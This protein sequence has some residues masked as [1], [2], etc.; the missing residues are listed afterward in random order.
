[1]SGSENAKSTTEDTSSLMHLDRQLID[2]LNRRVELVR[3]IGPLIAP[4]V[5]QWHTLLEK[6]AGNEPLIIDWLKHAASLSDRLANP[7]QSIAYLGPMYSFSYLAAA[8]YFGMGAHLVPVNTISAAFEEVQRK[9]ASFAVVPV[10]NNTDGRVVDSLG[11]F[12]KSPVQICGEILLPIHHC[13]LGR[14]DRNE[15]REV[16]SKPQA[17]SQC[18]H[19][20]ATHLPNVKLVEVASTAEAAT[21]AANS[22]SVAAIAS[23]EAGIHYGCKVIAENIEDNTQNIT[24]FAVIGDRHC[25]PT[26]N[27]KTS[28]MFQ[29]SHQ[30]GALA[31]AMIVFKQAGVN[32]TWIESFPLPNRPNEYLFFIELDG[33]RE[34][35]QVKL[36]IA[37]LRSHAVR[38]DVLG[39][40]PKGQVG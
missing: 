29:L 23:R 24:R 11:M 12:A 20:L 16:H 17:L 10:E 37:Q 5:T 32:L 25:P 14:A 2:L 30:P 34:S 8:R 31:D 27:D 19:W 4:S 1:M 21:T 36:S 40:Y 38:L 28:L 3:R 22:E 26:G 9:Q 35:E 33:H 18:R 7:Q 15:I 39:S 6:F 13:L